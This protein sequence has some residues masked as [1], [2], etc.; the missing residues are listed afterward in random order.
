MKDNIPQDIPED[1]CMQV[2]IAFEHFKELARQNGATFI[3]VWS[4]FDKLTH[5]EIVVPAF[6]GQVSTA[7]GLISTIE[8]KISDEEADRVMNNKIVIVESAVEVDKEGHIHV[9]IYNSADSVVP[10]DEDDGDDDGS[11]CPR[12]S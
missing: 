11:Q 6:E 5:Q 1:A 2:A 8:D 9:A 4:V 7:R 10:I 12:S 3:A